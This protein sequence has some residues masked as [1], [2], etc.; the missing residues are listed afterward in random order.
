MMT[1]TMKHLLFAP[2]PSDPPSLR[3]GIGGDIPVYPL[4][5]A[6]LSVG[7]GFALQSMTGIQGSV[8][9]Q[10]DTFRYGAA[11]LLVG[12]GIVLKKQCDVALQRAGTTALFKPVSSVAD[13]G[14]YAVCRNPMYWCILFLILAIGL[15]SNTLWVA[16][17]SNI[18][19]FFYLDWIVVP[20][21][22]SF[23]QQELGDSYKQYCSSVKRWFPK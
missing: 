7:S 3:I 10:C 2:P 11:V 19:F 14:P 22:E 21:E 12:I 13:T 4:L 1:S 8:L 5:A 16:I 20:A 18:V 9:Q 15:A 6:A 23:L 17:G